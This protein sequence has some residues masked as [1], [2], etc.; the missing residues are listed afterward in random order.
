MLAIDMAEADAAMLNKTYRWQGRHGKGAMRS[1]RWQK[2]EDAI[3]RN[4]WY[5]ERGKIPADPHYRAIAE[6]F[7]EV[8]HVA[9]DKNG[10]S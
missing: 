7:P 1:Y 3:R 6:R 10:K 4:A 9:A 2:R 5:L 8:Y